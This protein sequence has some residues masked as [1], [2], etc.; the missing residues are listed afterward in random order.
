MYQT[1]KHLTCIGAF[2]CLPSAMVLSG[3][4]QHLPFIQLAGWARFWILRIKIL[5]VVPRSSTFCVLMAL[6]LSHILN[7]WHKMFSI[8]LVFY[9]VTNCIFPREFYLVPLPLNV[10]QLCFRALSSNICRTSWNKNK[11]ES[12]FIW[13]VSDHVRSDW[14]FFLKKSYPP[15]YC[16]LCSSQLIVSFSTFFW[17]LVI[18]YF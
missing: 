10:S 12:L 6:I 1:S 2:S 14:F 17:Y 5:L 13:R 18:K 15:L 11:L 9:N 8:Q 16:T 3:M 7:V 4:L